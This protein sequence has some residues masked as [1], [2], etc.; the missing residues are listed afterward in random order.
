MER[1]QKFGIM[2][3]LFFILFS[4]FAFSQS[5]ITDLA[6][7]T[8]GKFLYD[9]NIKIET[10]TLDIY[11]R[12]NDIGFCY[13]LDFVSNNK[14]TKHLSNKY[15]KKIIGSE[16]DWDSNESLFNADD[17]QF[18]RS[19]EDEEYYF[20]NEEYLSSDKNRYNNYKEHVKINNI[21]YLFT[22][23]NSN[24]KILAEYS[25]DEFN[26]FK[27]SNYVN[28]EEI[29][30]FNSISKAYEFLN[31][32]EV[33]NQGALLKKVQDE[34]IQSENEMRK[35]PITSF[36]L[37]YKIRFGISESDVEKHL[38]NL[39]GYFKKTIEDQLTYNIAYKRGIYKEV[40]YEIKDGYS[41]LNLYLRFYQNKVFQIGYL[42]NSNYSDNN[43]LDNEIWLK[44]SEIE[45][46]YYVLFDIGKGSRDYKNAIWIIEE[47][48]KYEKEYK[49]LL[50]NE[51]Q[52]EKNR[53]N[54]IGKKM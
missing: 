42:H 31:S 43:K 53:E 50:D 52:A 34:L 38:T 27:N 39:F 48:E 4:T 1:K 21:Y 6:D 44:L 45:N 20:E 19:L 46:K 47:N 40:E 15:I 30:I 35:I 14:S 16:T 51:V 29:I 54:R 26:P 18:N 33:I 9:K 12:V 3:I 11:I 10:D 49:M 22:K 28:S 37:P 32:F 23:S 5:F 25:I 7:K 41:Q 24:Y 8:V 13:A 2:R 36:E 17:N